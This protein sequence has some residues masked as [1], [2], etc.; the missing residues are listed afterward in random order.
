M[1]VYP[2]AHEG[3]RRLLNQ[4][5]RLAVQTG[6]ARLIVKTAAEAH[7]IPTIAENVAALE[8]AAAP[9][10]AGRRAPPAGEIPDTGIYAE[11]K[12]LV[13]AVVDLEPD[14]GRALA[15]AFRRGARDIPSRLHPDN[16]GRARSYLDGTGR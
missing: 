12:A 2:G 5:V 10:P 3:A 8:T 1:G 9:P 15:T 14:L 6:A 16:A 13:D 4:A 11:A 7:R